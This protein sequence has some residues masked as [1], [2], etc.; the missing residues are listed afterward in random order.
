MTHH[1]INK[2]YIQN[3]REDR[4]TDPDKNKIERLDLG[5]FLFQEVFK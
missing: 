3:M 5:I 1:G 4:V 2:F